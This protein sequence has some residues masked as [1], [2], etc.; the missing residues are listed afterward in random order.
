MYST[1]D[2]TIVRNVARRFASQYPYPDFDDLVQEGLLRV[3]K[4]RG[5]Y[6]PER[7]GPFQAH[8]I[9]CLTNAFRD[10][11]RKDLRRLAVLR[12]AEDEKHGDTP[13]PRAVDPIRAM[14]RHEWLTRLRRAIPRLSPVE[15]TVVELM[16]Q[17][18]EDTEIIR[19][20][21]R[22]PSAIQTARCRAIPRLRDLL[23]G[24]LLPA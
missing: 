12:P 2:E 5:S 20:T 18:A 1:E 23:A 17:D 15:Q 4:A 22:T 8:L 7:A 10:I 19:V 21:G 9:F 3:G 13:C 24:D 6:D 16:L 14:L 11:V